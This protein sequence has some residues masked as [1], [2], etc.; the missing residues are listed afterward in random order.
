MPLLPR[1][2]SRSHAEQLNSHMERGLV[3]FPNALHAD[4]V[5]EMRWWGVG[6]IFDFGLNGLVGL[7]RP[8]VMVEIDRGKLCGIFNRLRRRRSYSVNYLSSLQAKSLPNYLFLPDFR[9]PEEQVAIGV[10]GSE[11]PFFR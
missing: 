10:G 8:S 3:I 4:D 5:D 9:T 6:F 7:G 2:A 11:N 1:L